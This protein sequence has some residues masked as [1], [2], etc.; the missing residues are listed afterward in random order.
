MHSTKQLSGASNDKSHHMGH[1]AP[2]EDGHEHEHGQRRECDAKGAAGH[3]P[4]V[5]ESTQPDK[6]RV[7]RERRGVDVEVPRV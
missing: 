7:H 2:A 1:D 6:A 5:E 4:L 3:R